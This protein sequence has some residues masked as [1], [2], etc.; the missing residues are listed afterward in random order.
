M[1]VLIII[2]L[3]AGCSPMPK[4]S[5][6]PEHITNNNIKWKMLAPHIKKHFNTDMTVKEIAAELSYQEY[7]LAKEKEN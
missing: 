2:L 1:R 7:L 6:V 3:L 5:V 4:P